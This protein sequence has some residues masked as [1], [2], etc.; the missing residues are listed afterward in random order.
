M[1]RKSN[2]TESLLP[3]AFCPADMEIASVSLHEVDGSALNWLI[4]IVM[5]HSLRFYDSWHLAQVDRC[6]S[7]SAWV[8]AAHEISYHPLRGQ[9]VSE[10][11]L[12]RRR[13]TGDDWISTEVRP[14][15]NVLESL[16]SAVELMDLFGV[17]VCPLHVDGSVDEV[18]V[19]SAQVVEEGVQG[20][21][22]PKAQSTHFPTAVARAIVLFHVQGPLVGVPAHL[23]ST[24]PVLR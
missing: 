16:D 15:T 22:S 1:G 2:A 6:F 5:G 10:H 8:D 3:G 23:L 18:R 21:T 24:A 7:G 20:M 19:W 14:L 4:A 11:K 12:R 17:S 9:W 13:R